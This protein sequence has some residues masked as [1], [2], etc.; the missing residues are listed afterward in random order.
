MS[1]LSDKKT[2]TLPAFKVAMA[3]IAGSRKAPPF[4]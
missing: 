3:F 1:L 4:V 2:S